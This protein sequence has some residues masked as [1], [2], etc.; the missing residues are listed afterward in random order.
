MVWP[1]VVAV[2]LKPECSRS[3]EPF[4]EAPTTLARESQRHNGPLISLLSRDDRRMSSGFPDRK[5]WPRGSMENIPQ[6]R[7][8]PNARIKGAN[9]RLTDDQGRCKAQSFGPNAMENVE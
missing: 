9:A 6:G 2:R 3:S 4:V 8:A 5:N 7:G 1:P